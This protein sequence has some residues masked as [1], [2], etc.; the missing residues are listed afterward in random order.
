MPAS[1]SK[2][3]DNNWWFSTT[4]VH[5]SAEN[6]EN[7]QKKSVGDIGENKVRKPYEDKLA[8]TGRRGQFLRK[9]SF[10]GGWD[11]LDNVKLKLNHTLPF[12]S[13]PEQR[14]KIWSLESWKN[15]ES[16]AQG[17][18]VG[19]LPPGEFIKPFNPSD[20]TLKGRSNTPQPVIRYPMTGGHCGR[21]QRI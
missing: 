6:F 19:N 5:C 17:G 20:L 3:E 18:Q 13:K 10:L 7:S 11:T 16:S 1:A 8:G 12:G 2:W 21:V 4:N 15:L 9:H 14:K